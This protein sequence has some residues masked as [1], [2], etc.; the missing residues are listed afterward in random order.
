MYN[1]MIFKRFHVWSIQEPACALCFVASTQGHSQEGAQAPPPS[2]W[3]GPRERTTFEVFPI[4]SGGA[5]V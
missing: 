2:L 5:Q 4:G 3:G 1:G